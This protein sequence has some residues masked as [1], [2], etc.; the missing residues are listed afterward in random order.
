MLR[1]RP[2]RLAL[3]AAVVLS[4]GGCASVT[5]GSG[6][7][8]APTAPSSTSGPDFPSSSA[9]APPTPTPPSTAAAPA[10]S[11]ATPGPDQRRAALL[12]Q[13][14]GQRV[15]ALVGVPGGYE[16][17]TY[18]Q[19][20]SIRFWAESA[21]GSTW[22]LIGASRYPYSAS[23]GA[24]GAAVEG[25]RLRN[26]QHATFI[27]TG[28]FTTDGSGNAVAFTTGSRGWGA[29]KAEANGNIGPSGQPVGRNRIGLSYG[30]AF[31]DG[32]LITGDCPPNRPIAQCG[33]HPVVK[34]WVWTG[35]EFRRV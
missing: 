3:A 29:V 15:S 31:A 10:S 22:R 23:L 24:P 12:G 13:A 28:V 34:R 18:D 27:V 19:R 33:R 1:A 26:M 16:A 8:G 32:Y 5:G 14:A 30:F 17:A 2:L 21:A 11:A 20:G 4:A 25:A 6:T 35:S 7:A 9:S